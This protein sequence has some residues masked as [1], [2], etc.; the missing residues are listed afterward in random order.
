MLP[1]G[2]H[3]LR[4]LVAHAW[5]TYSDFGASSLF[6]CL[7]SHILDIRPSIAF[8]GLCAHTHHDL[9]LA[10]ADAG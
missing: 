7:L 8:H 1:F 2:T 5:P 6:C 4:S 3:T 10:Q 9:N